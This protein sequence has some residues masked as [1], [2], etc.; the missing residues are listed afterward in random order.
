[1]VE[2]PATDHADDSSASLVV[3]RELF[4]GHSATC[5]D[6]GPA[7]WAVAYG[8]REFDTAAWTE[9]DTSSLFQHFLAYIIPGTRPGVNNPAIPA[10]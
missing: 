5:G 6:S 3:T 7:V 10:C 4:L 2:Q 9:F 1:M 8:A